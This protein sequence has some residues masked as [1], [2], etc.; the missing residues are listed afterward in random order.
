[1]VFEVKKMMEQLY[2][3]KDKADCYFTLLI[4][5]ERALVWDTMIVVY[6]ARYTLEADEHKYKK[7][8]YIGL[9]LLQYA[10]QRRKHI[11]MCVEEIQNLYTYGPCGKPY[12]KGYE[13]FHFNM[14]HC[15]GWVACVIADDP[16]GIDVERVGSVSSGMIQK[17]L[18]EKEQKYLNQYKEQ[19]SEYGAV[20]YRFW[21]LKESYLKWCGKGFLKDPRQVEFSFIEEENEN[22]IL[23]SDHKIT[24]RQMSLDTDCLMSICY[25]GKEEKVY[26]ES[27]MYEAIYPI[28]IK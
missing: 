15:D 1:M 21:T 9:V 23:C 18:T 7:E 14:S 28:D 22:K 2:L 12:L 10:L 8:H 27:Y 16:I 3:I 26:Y 13:N 19:T 4:G 20:F 17:M 6:N 24:C 25:E 5:E 11:S